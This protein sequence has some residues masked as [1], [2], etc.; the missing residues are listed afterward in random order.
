ML[1][2]SIEQAEIFGTI[3]VHL[4]DAT[5]ITTLLPGADRASFKEHDAD[6]ALEPVDADAGEPEP[7]FEDERDEEESDEFSRRIGAIEIAEVDLGKNNGSPES[8][9]P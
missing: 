4:I 2:R 8:P 6:V 1:F 9:T 5:P 7:V 3:D